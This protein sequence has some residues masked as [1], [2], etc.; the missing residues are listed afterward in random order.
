MF[1]LKIQF[2]VKGISLIRFNIVMTKRQSKR[3][4]NRNNRQPP[5][6]NQPPSSILHFYYFQNTNLNSTAAIF[7][8]KHMQITAIW[9]LMPYFMLNPLQP[10]T[11][12]VLLPIIP[13]QVISIPALT[14]T[15]QQQFER[16]NHRITELE[17][18]GHRVQP[19]AQCKNPNYC[20]C[21]LVPWKIKGRSGECCLPDPMKFPW[22]CLPTEK[23][24]RNCLCA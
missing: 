4:W 12:T 23:E 19:P 2:F 10:I 9:W 17:L 18:Q 11:N 1:L 3:N 8:A 5:N 15:S 6:T 24:L 21:L 22:F 13:R 16:K 7:E 14:K 20:D